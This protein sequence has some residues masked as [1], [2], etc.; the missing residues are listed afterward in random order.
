MINYF[1]RS[2]TVLFLWILCIVFNII[3]FLFIYYKIHPTNKILALHYNVVTGV[4]WYGTGKNLY[5]FP[6]V[7]AGITIINY[8]IYRYARRTGDLMAPLSAFVSFLIQVLVLI[9]ALFLLQV[10]V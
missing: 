5:T 7:S 6:A 1:K 4:D 9:A 2:R 3:T 10:N 8:I